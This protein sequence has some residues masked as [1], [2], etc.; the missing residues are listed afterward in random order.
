MANGNGFVNE[1]TFTWAWRLLVGLLLSVLAFYA[2]DMHGAVYKE[3]P[4]A[5][6]QTE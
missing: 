6:H 4:K 3:I 2:A 1:R 5:I